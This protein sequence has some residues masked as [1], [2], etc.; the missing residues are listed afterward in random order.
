MNIWTKAVTSPQTDE[1]I[2]VAGGSIRRTLVVAIIFGALA[3]WTYAVRGIH[4]YARSMSGWSDGASKRAG[5]DWTP[6]IILWC[7]PVL[8]AGLIGL[9]IR[10]SMMKK[11]EP[12]QA[13]EPTAPSG[14]GS[15]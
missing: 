6:F 5:D 10:A 1:R 2:R 9:M 11:K 3:L 8:L 4:D 12:N 15:S 7:V 13:L 14:R